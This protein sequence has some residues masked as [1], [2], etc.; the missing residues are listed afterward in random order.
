MSTSSIN[1]NSANTAMAIVMI[2]LAV[3]L[4]GGL[5]V[6]PALQQEVDARCELFKK[7]GDPCKPKKDKV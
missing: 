5:A 3:M 1:N 7:N 4:I 6:I 2:A